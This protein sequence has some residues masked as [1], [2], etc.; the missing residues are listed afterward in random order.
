MSGI[1]VEDGM[2]FAGHAPDRRR[3][4]QDVALIERF[5]RERNAARVDLKEVVD[6]LQTLSDAVDA[7]GK[8]DCED[9]HSAEWDALLAA[10]RAAR[11]VLQKAR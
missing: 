8:L 10:D 9:I 5:R 2:G 3:I 1:E 7:Y 4:P 6:A 11:K